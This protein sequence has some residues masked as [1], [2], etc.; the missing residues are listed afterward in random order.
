MNFDLVAVCAVDQ[1]LPDGGRV[2]V[3]G[4]IEVESVLFGQRFERGIGEGTAFIGTLPAHGCDRALVD[5]QLL[6]RNDEVDIEFH[7]VA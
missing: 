2:L 7:L 3:P 6:V 5:R 1:D 4:R